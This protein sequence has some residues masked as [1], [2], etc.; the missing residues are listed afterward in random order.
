MNIIEQLEKEQIDELLAKREV[1]EFG[2][3]DTVRVNVNVIEGTRSRIQ[4][5][6]GVCIGRSGKGLHENFTVRK[7]SY[8]EGVERIFPVF[9][10]LIDSIDVV[11]RG[12]VRRAKLYYLRGLRGKAARILERQDKKGT[13]KKKKKEKFKGFDR[14]SGD[15]DDLTRIEGLNKTIQTQINKLGIIQLEQIAN[16]S[17]DDIVKLDEALGLS[18]KIEKD[19]W[20]RKAREAMTEATVDEVPEIEEETTEGEDVQASTPGGDSASDEAEQADDADKK[21]D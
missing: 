4:A 2:P 15:A 14:P 10:P 21:D 16:L 13:V 9:S 19:D 5:Y 20:V 18:G 1:P 8:G 6:E 17:D 11:R 3:G 7:I 12:K